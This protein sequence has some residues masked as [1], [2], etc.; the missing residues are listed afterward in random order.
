MVKRA[1]KY[2][3]TIIRHGSGR[4]EHLLAYEGM[5]Y[6]N[7]SKSYFDRRE[8]AEAHQRSLARQHKAAANPN[9]IKLYKVRIFKTQLGWGVFSVT[10]TG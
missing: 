2:V 3:V 4:E 8:R 10:I 5:I 1:V 9:W 7:W 6:S